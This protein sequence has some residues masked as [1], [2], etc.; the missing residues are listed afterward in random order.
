ML[1]YSN[2]LIVFPLDLL[3]SQ[4]RQFSI[5]FK[6]IRYHL[7]TLSLCLGWI[8]IKNIQPLIDQVRIYSIDG[9]FSLIPET[10]LIFQTLP[11]KSFGSS[12]LLKVTK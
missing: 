7:H 3:S 1:Q 12:K 4:L 11:F 8:N 10:R 2:H 6:F 5:T 9:G